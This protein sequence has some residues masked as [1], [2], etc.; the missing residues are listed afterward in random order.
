MDKAER[1]RSLKHYWT[2]RGKTYLSEGVHPSPERWVKIADAIIRNLRRLRFR[3]LL[4]VGCGYGSCLNLVRMNIPG[5]R[6]VGVDISKTMIQS[7]LE[8]LG[9]GI[10]LLVADASNLPFK[11]SGFDL[12]FTNV[13]LIHIPPGR[14]EEAVMEIL[15]VAGEGFFVETSVK[16]PTAPYYF[17]HDYPELFE[18][19]GLEWSV[20]ETIEPETERRIYLVG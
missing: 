16:G 6:L 18:S 11:D 15:R 12:A 5:I 3:S 19:L 17:T 9:Y 10:P 20:L 8:Y 14:I 1:M 13:C 7:A 4:E 2:E